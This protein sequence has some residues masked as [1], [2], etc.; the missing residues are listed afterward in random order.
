[1]MPHWPPPSADAEIGGAALLRG[2]V[3]SEQPEGFAVRITLGNTERVLTMEVLASG[4]R[5]ASV[6]RGDRV[7]CWIDGDA[8]A[9]VILGV[10]GGGQEA[11]SRPSHAAVDAPDEL[12]I[13]AKHSLTLRVGD[14]SITIREDGK[15]L[16][17]GKDLVS[18]AQRMNRIKGGAV[19]IN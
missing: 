13:E 5:T 16:I 18:H 19:S 10:L 2:E 7:L 4:F 14:G 12:V 6:H 1:M 11:T 9:G 8:N 3:V 15:I 17:K